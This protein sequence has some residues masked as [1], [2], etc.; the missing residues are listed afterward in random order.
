M[1]TCYV[2]CR[3]KNDDY[4]HKGMEGGGQRVISESDDYDGL[5]LRMLSGSTGRP[6]VS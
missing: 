3:D 1:V 4:H 2:I 5:P 6:W